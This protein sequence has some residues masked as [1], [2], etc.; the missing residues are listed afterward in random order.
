MTGLSTRMAPVEVKTK[1]SQ[2]NDV[3]EKSETLL[4]G[5]LSLDKFC[6]PKKLAEKIII[7]L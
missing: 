4:K 1:Q 7:Y 2:K 5:V 6:F 3:V